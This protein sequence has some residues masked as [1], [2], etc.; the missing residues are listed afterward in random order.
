MSLIK[1]RTG[2]F[3]EIEKITVESE[4]KKS[5]WV[6]GRCF[7]KRGSYK[8]YFDTAQEAAQAVI[9]KSEKRVSECRSRLENYTNALKTAEHLLEKRRAQLKDYLV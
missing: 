2:G 1:Y 8:E 4:T 6:N 5:V 3:P 7:R 9:F